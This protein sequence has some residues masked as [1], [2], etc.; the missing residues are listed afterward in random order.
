MRLGVKTKAQKYTLGAVLMTALALFVFLAPSSASAAT[1]INQT[2]EFQGRLL[3]AQGAT[4]PDGFYNIE[5]KVY[6]DGN[7]LSA[8]DTTGTPAGTLD[9]TE[10]YLNYNSQGVKVVNGFFSVELGSITPFGASVNWNQNTLWLSMNVAGVSTTCTTFS[11]CTPDGEM[12]PM[13]R[14]TASPYALNAGELNGLSSTQFV[15]L[16][17]GLQTDSSA[18][19]SIY[20]NKTGTGNLVQLQAAGNDAFTLNNTGDLT[21][22]A[23]TTAHS[24]S[25]A[26]A[27]ASTAG[28]ALS[29]T[30]GAAGTGATTLAGGNLTLSAGAGGGTNGNGGNVIIDA[31]LANGTGTNGTVSIGTTNTSSTS[32]GNTTG[33][34]ALTLSVGTGNFSLNGVGASTYAIG[35]AT[36]T[37]TITLG[38]SS[39]TG[40]LVLQ[41]QGITNTITG[42]ATAPSE[43]LQT[44]A[45]STAAYAVENSTGKYVLRVDTTNN[46]LVLGQSSST[47]GSIAFKNSNGANSITLNSTAANTTYTLTLPSSAPNPGLCIETSSSS[48]SQLVFASCSN[49]NASITEVAEW[50]ANATNALTIAPSSVGDEVI[51]TT[52]IPNSGTTV[53]S[54]S[55]G[56]VGSWTKIV[57]NNGDGT[58]NRV[59]MWAGTVT[60]AGSST[61]TV[62]YSGTASNEEVTATEFTAAGVN[63][64]TNWG[65]GTVGAQLN[66]TASSTVTFPNLNSISSDELYF[67]YGQVQNPP[68]TAG[69][70]AGFNYIVT[71]TQHNIITY[72]SSTNAN[73]SY[74]PTANQNTAGESNTIGAVLTA[75]VTSTAINN[76]T[77]IQQANFY[78][79]AAT[80]GSAAGVLQANS[81][82][83]GDVLDLKASTGTNIA[84]VTST[85]V[86]TFKN[87]ANSTRAFQVQNL[88]GNNVVSVNT[89]T[90][91]LA[92]GASAALPGNLAFLDSSDTNSIALAAPSSI[93]ASYT[94]TLPS[95]TPTAGLCL[96]TSPSNA[97]QLIFASCAT[98]VAVGT[99]SYVTEWNTSSGTGVTTLAD[100]PTNVGD[101]LVF[102]SKAA[103]NITVSSIS[104]GGV[105]TWSK[106]TSAYSTNAGEMEMWRGVVTAAGAGTITVTYS[107]AEGANELVTQEFTMHSAN[108]TWAIDNSGNTYNTTTS[109]TVNYPSLTPTN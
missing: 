54:V 98:Q 8:G 100:S 66:S 86:T 38:G 50:D 65:I 32:I 6:Q 33:A 28:V 26:T 18:N 9:W 29:I 35:G 81:S 52:Q 7:G 30:A 106:T 87:S 46:Q 99:I 2:I 67:G 95:N 103:N 108:S 83:L 90:N 104:G 24:I 73:T 1:G 43:L 45:N 14:L 15:W 25:V 27:P 23:N 11:A 62:T 55:G 84:S 16:G 40:N 85:G 10:D 56:G 19:S 76:S 78:V 91:Q 20:I 74:Q 101:L 4:V 105:T 13:Q 77:S 36:T 57:A 63:A 22:G 97:T 80:S 70:S 37:G 17:Q 69:T 42:S 34:N 94:L 41:G 75:F 58:V 59:E 61:I 102:Y 53:S 107:G 82:G 31:G 48:A 51:L 68:S 72:N 79:Q 3:N 93:A 49:T 12:L 21:F 89:T 88:S 5:F 44:S 47:N 64:S 109:T 60:T 92:L 71:S 96:G 39:Q